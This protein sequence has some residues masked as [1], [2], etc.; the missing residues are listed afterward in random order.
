M[1]VADEKKTLGTGHDT[2]FLKH[3]HN[4]DWLLDSIEM[5]PYVSAAIGL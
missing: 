3:Y 4:L 2:H 1:L 5:N